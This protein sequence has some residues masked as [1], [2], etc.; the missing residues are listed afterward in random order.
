ML[1]SFLLL[2]VIVGNFNVFHWSN[3]SNDDIVC[4]LNVSPGPSPPLNPLVISELRTVVK[5][6]HIEL[7]STLKMFLISIIVG[8]LVLLSL[9]KPLF[10]FNAPSC[11]STTYTNLF[12]LLL[13]LLFFIIFEFYFIIILPREFFKVKLVNK[14][15]QASRIVKFFNCCSS[16]F[17]FYVYKKISCLIFRSLPDLN[18]YPCEV[19]AL[20]YFV[21]RLIVCPGINPNPGP[22]ITTP[23]CQNNLFNFMSWNLNSLAKDNFQRVSLIEA[24]NSIFNYDLIYI[25][26]TSLNDSVEL[27]EPLLNDY[28]F[29]PANNPAN[30]RHGGVGLFYKNSFPVVVRNDLSFDESIVVELKFGRKKILFTVLYRSPAFDHNSSN[31]QVFLSNFR[32]LHAKIKAENPF[33]TFFTGD[34]NAHSQFW[35]PDGD[36]TPEGN[37]IEHLLTLLGL[38]QVISEPTNFEPNK[39]PSCIDL[40]ITDH[41][42]LILASGTR[43]S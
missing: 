10:S 27:P 16:N 25:C 37:E 12:L 5:N 28:T 29:V 36:S 8:L 19:F 32:N 18:F 26:E 6:L 38:S 2:G 20:W 4:N 13:I 9:D 30:T 23:H 17:S 21:V 35:W 31:F 11:R 14:I 7:A 1:N 40:V 22:P 43:S 24:H 39:N 42:N 15:K 41:P 3:L 33:A 34:F